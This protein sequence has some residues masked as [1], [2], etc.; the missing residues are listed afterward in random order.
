[1]DR[2]DL[3]IEVDSVTYDDINSEAHEESSEIV[4]E[5]VNKARKIQQERFKGKIHSNS[6]MSSQMVKKYCELSPTCEAL[7]KTAFERFNLTAR[8]YNRI[9]KVARTIADLEGAEKIE[10][11]HLLE[12]INYRSLDSKY[13]S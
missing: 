2:I 11:A 8:A 6:E 13:F 1:M 9:L 12:A 7:I 4:K 3:H 10:T 5:R